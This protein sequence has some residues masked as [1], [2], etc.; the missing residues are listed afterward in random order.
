MD[1]LIERAEY[2]HEHGIFDAAEAGKAVSY[3]ELA[4]TIRTLRAERDLFAEN[5]KNSVAAIVAYLKAAAS[6]ADEKADKAQNAESRRNWVAT[7]MAAA[8]LAQYIERG[9]Y[10]EPKA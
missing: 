8:H 7:N 1:D 6:E 3:G 4:A 9:E 2:C 10:K 5:A